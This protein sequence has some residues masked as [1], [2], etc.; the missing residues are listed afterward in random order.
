M[1]ARMVMPMRRTRGCLQEQGPTAVPIAG[2]EALAAGDQLP[3]W[4]DVDIAAPFLVEALGVN[5]GH[6]DLLQPGRVVLSPAVGCDK[7]EQ[8]R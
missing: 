7:A 8:G 1:A 2:V 4:H 5:H 3:G 6:V